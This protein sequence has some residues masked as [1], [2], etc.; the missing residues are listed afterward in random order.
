LVHKKH[1]KKLASAK[2]GEGGDLV[3]IYSHHPFDDAKL[4][5][6]PHEALIMLVQKVFLKIESSNQPVFTKVQSQLLQLGEVMKE[7]MEDVWAEKKLYPGELRE[8]SS[9]N[10]AKL[11]EQTA[12]MVDKALVRQ[13]LWR[14]LHLVLGRLFHC[15]C[16][17]DVNRLKN[18]R[19]VIPEELWVGIQQEVGPF[20]SRVAQLIKAMSG[21]QLPSFQELLKV[22]C[23]GTLLHAC[24]VCNTSMTVAAVFGEVEGAYSGTPSVLLFPHLPPLF[25]CGASICGEE[26]CAKR[27]AYYGKWRTGLVATFLKLWP[28]KC[29]FC[30]QLPE[31]VHRCMSCL[32]KTYCSKDCLV[33]DWEER[34]KELC[35]VGREEWKVK[36]GTEGRVE[37]GLKHIEGGLQRAMMSGLKPWELQNVVEVK[38]MCEKMGSADKAEKDVKHKKLCKKVKGDSKEHCGEVKLGVSKMKISEPVKEDMMEVAKSS[39]KLGSRGKAERGAKKTRGKGGKLVQG[40]ENVQGGG[41]RGSVPEVD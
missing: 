36:R 14:T 19:E 5:D 18:P 32:T 11:Y 40:E 2:E 16:V 21:T 27:E 25:N 38:E 4:S 23:G 3:G 9:P 22:F 33:K 1:C 13:D 6:V 10:C 24:S 30:F 17:N 28:N 8:F 37:T 31:K 29:D 15:Q 20:P 7:C 34:H 12:G 26:I 35:K 41:E 39:Q